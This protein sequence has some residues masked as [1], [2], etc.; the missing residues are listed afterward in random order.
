MHVSAV[1]IGVWAVAA[2]VGLYGGWLIVS[3]L[4]LAYDKDRFLVRLPGTWSTVVVIV[5]VFSSK[6]YLGYTAATDP[7][8]VG[9]G[10]NLLALAVSGFGTG[11]VTG[12]VVGYFYRFLSSTSVRLES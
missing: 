6:F 11:V 1:Q 4:A 5:L 10:M 8:H 9:T 3:R 7:T 2:A 12:R